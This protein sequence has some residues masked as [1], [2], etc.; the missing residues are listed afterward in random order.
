MAFRPPVVHGS[1]QVGGGPWRSGRFLL[2]ARPGT[3]PGRRRRG[4]VAG[5][6]RASVSA[7][8]GPWQVRRAVLAIGGSRPG[9]L[10]HCC[11]ALSRCPFEDARTPYFGEKVTLLELR[12]LR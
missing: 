8:P 12:D 11:C 4:A 3:P 9:H 7:A 2:P 1:P 6:Q 10:S 5:R